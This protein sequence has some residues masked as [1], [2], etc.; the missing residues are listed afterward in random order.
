LL[1]LVFVDFHSNSRPLSVVSK[2]PW[3]GQLV[4][5]QNS[6][7]ELTLYRAPCCIHREI[8]QYRK[9]TQGMQTWPLLAASV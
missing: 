8:W 5:K 7:T 6:P 2:D 4:V 1:G 9:S 3:L